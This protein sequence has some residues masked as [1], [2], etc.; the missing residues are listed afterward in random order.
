MP[1]VTMPSAPSVMRAFSRGPAP[2]LSTKRHGG[3]AVIA[4]VNALAGERLFLVVAELG[5]QRSKAAT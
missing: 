2:P 4:A 5:R 3:D 1:T